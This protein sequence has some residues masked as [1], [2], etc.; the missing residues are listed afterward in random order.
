MNPA[1]LI[2]QFQNITTGALKQ[3]E[4]T[5]VVKFL[6]ATVK[7]LE[8]VTKKI[9]GF[10]KSKNIDV[11][12][13]LKQLSESTS[14]AADKARGVLG[15]YKDE[16]KNKGF[17][18]FIKSK[19]N[20]VQSMMTEK[21]ASDTETSGAP[22]DD[23]NP[24]IIAKLQASI[25]TL[26]DSIENLAKK[27]LP[28]GFAGGA[29]D[30]GVT[31][32]RSSNSS[33]Y[34]DALRKSKERAET[35]KKEI[36]Q[37]KE[38]VR[39]KSKPK[40]AKQTSWLSKIL[41]TVGRI[42]PFIVGGLGRVIT[43]AI[44]ALVGLTGKMMGGILTRLTPKLA[45]LI[46]RGT[47][48]LVA[49]GAKMAGRGLWGA[50]KF[51]AT[52][53][54]PALLAGAKALGGA[55]VTTV[56]TAGLAIGGAVV[57]VG[58]LIY[59]GYKL[60]KYLNRNN[61]ANDIFG[62]LTRL[63]L[64]MYG[65]NDT[66]KEHYYR[67]MELEMMMKDY[68][69]VKDGRVSM[70][71]LDTKLKDKVKDL[72]EVK[73]DEK[74]KYAILNT[75]FARRFMPAFKAFMDAFMPLGPN[76][77]LD[78]IDKLTNDQVLTLASKLIPPTTIYDIK[79]VPTFD[80]PQT[81]VVKQQV[82]DMLASIRNKAKTNSTQLNG[83]DPQ[84]VKETVDK[85]TG[86]AATIATAKANQTTQAGIPKGA[87]GGTNPPPI[88]RELTNNPTSK[89]NTPLSKTETPNQEG[90][91]PVR[92]VPG[93]PPVPAPS[94]APSEATKLNI[95]PGKLQ[96]GDKSLQGV[97]FGPKGDSSRLTGLHPKVFSL[98]TGMAKEFN[99]LTGKNITVNESFRTYED[100]MALRQK[101]PGKAAKPGNSI[102]E[103]GMALDVNS[104]EA[105]L[106]D[107]MGLLRKYGFTRPVGGETWHL[108]PAGVAVNPQAAK[109]NPQ[110]R[111]QALDSSPGR[112]GGGYG[113]SKSTPLGKRN[114]QLQAKLFSEG[115]ASTVDTASISEEVKDT[116][117]FSGPATIPTAPQ[118]NASTNNPPTPSKQPEPPPANPPSMMASGYGGSV[119]KTLTQ[120]SLSLSG[121]STTPNNSLDTP[122]T[123]PS[124][125]NLDPG[126]IGSKDLSPAQAVRKAA[127][128]VGMDPEAMV[129]FAKLESSLDPKA[130][131]TTS[132][133]KGLFQITKPTWNGLLPK[134]G[135]KYNVPE[136][137]DIFDPY[138]N[139]VIG[140]SYAKQ[141]AQSVLPQGQQAGL[142][143][144][145]SLYLAHH[146]GPSGSKRLIQAYLSN[147]N[148]STQGAVSSSTFSANQAALAGKTVGQ[149][150]QSLVSKMATAASTPETAYKG[151]KGYNQDQTTES[152]T[153]SSTD[154]LPDVQ[155]SSVYTPSAKPVSTP[156]MG[157]RLQR[158]EMPTPTPA[159]PPT[160]SYPVQQ[161]VAR[162]T[163]LPPQPSM[164]LTMDPTNEILNSQL[165]VLSDIKRI[166]EG[167][168]GQVPRSATAPTTPVAPNTTQAAATPAPSAPTQPQSPIAAPMNR[169]PSNSSVSMS[170]RQ[171][172]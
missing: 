33:D 8:G 168:T 68:V 107:E 154:A 93:Q 150:I 57:G 59:G 80:D 4:N 75:W 117:A 105:N 160:T 13:R 159:P 152:Q 85:Q 155:T 104:P 1:E 165:S 81:S 74:E 109:A 106:L 103:F 11:S 77:Y 42:G 171:I 24:S 115:S 120:N 116:P 49:G 67:L 69:Q 27:S 7:T 39:N 164:T 113:A 61:V 19:A 137:A 9:D 48:K 28:A 26:T 140:I 97:T 5:G 64:L 45:G 119:S 122:A 124:N 65:F 72:F 139:S 35:R 36:E 23:Q 38:A 172:T 15:S 6:R 121:V 86:A 100:Q 102:H 17:R 98:F 118:P 51:A 166:L 169:T 47:S 50:A 55:L 156:P 126:A 54:A 87:I 151:M 34:A 37:E 96:P 21:F 110:A 89:T 128:V 29:E 52:R 90:E 83:Q 78:K 73:A 149:Y 46:A 123:K 66:K 40:D 161:S 82:D 127:N 125:A 91:T 135:P 108:E 60:Y 43:A 114:L 10:L 62:Q 58:L 41:G 136:N 99:T 22:P 153:K 167:L 129:T 79:Q 12:E 131:A 111:E 95:A 25:G 143:D 16:I 146:F 3:N 132:S 76:L 20:D 157:A 138:Y 92:D 145:L 163:P 94:G 18:G 53:A 31:T 170:R 147:P 133:A 32:S 112:G 141:N 101:Y 30:V 162:P 130:G 14:G 70:V 63:R 84:K 144:E 56:G 158:S 2:Q 148:Q 134:E 88:Q 142:P 44:P 71:K